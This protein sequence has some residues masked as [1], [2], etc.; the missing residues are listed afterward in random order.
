M[1]LTLEQGG[2]LVKYARAVIEGYFTSG[3]PEPPGSLREV[4]AEKRGVFVT[5]HKSGGLRGC[6]GLPEPTHPLGLAVEKAALSAAL[7]DP[8]FPD[9]KQDELDDIV[10]E[11][12]VLTHPKLVEVGDPKEYMENVC[13]GR[14]GLIA[15]K[16]WARGLLLPQVPGEWGW[17]SEDFICHTC[18]KA[19]LPSTAWL[20]K[21]FRLYSFQAQVF[22]E[23]SPR[24]EVVE[25]RLT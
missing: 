17:D 2:D 24:G 16:D 25:K 19:G 18:S 7:E 23:E 1:T 15:E 6:I 13:V 10:V 9:V 8:R 21:G 4:F 12:S 11:V 22:S 5:L 20:D 14:D 3:K